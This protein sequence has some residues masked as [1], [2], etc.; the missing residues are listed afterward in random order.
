MAE[1]GSPLLLRV[2][3]LLGDRAV[4]LPGGWLRSAA[5]AGLVLLVW[6][7]APV[8]SA[9]AVEAEGPQSEAAQHDPGGRV[10]GVPASGTTAGESPLTGSVS[11]Y[12]APSY[13]SAQRAGA[14]AASAGTRARLQD[15]VIRHPEPGE[16]LESRWQWAALE[17][18]R[19]AASNYWVAYAFER[20]LR[21]DQIHVEDSGSWS[22]DEFDDLPLGALIYGP[23]YERP[24]D[25]IAAGPP[26]QPQKA[27]GLVRQPVVVLFH[28]VQMRAGEPRVGRVSVRTASAGMNLRGAPLYWLGAAADAESF[29][30][31]RGRIQDLQDRRLRGTVIEAMAMHADAQRVVPFLEEVVTSDRPS[32][33]REEAVEGLAWHPTDRS[34][35]LLRAT[36]LDG[37][38]GSIREEATETLGELRTPAAA[39]ALDELLRTAR[40]D[41]VRA[42]AVEALAQQ[43]Q[44]EVLET[45]TRVALDDPDRDI[46][47]EAIEAIA[48]FPSAAAVPVL[49]R[50]ARTHPRTD[51]QSEAVEAL[52]DVDPAAA[53]DVLEQLLQ[54]DAPAELRDEAIDV[55]AERRSPE[56]LEAIFRVAMTDPDPDLQGEAVEKLAEF[57]PAAALPRLEQLAWEHPRLEVRE[58][59]VEA[60]AQ[61]PADLALPALDEIVMGHEDGPVVHEAIQAIAEFPSNVSMPRLLRILREH[62]RED[63]RHEALD[64]LADMRE[65]E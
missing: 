40:S 49:D 56:A 39:A 44:P 65:S 61:L 35:A 46:Q 31:L 29:D 19:R 1:G 16:P 53:A 28:M 2:E 51:M 12:P 45:L 48:S 36:A 27:S 42:E 22:T 50:I 10:A 26:N 60:L 52:G 63:A 8:V 33:V 64:Q 4:H 11:G 9:G 38:S 43:Q 24:A 54:A 57:D 34:I 17:A 62:P 15:E 59:A 6:I 3:R 58:E 14:G 5:A 47:E 25:A 13:S 7:A 18:E 21:A 23:S 55:L 37:R 32:D 41:E 20:M 30:W